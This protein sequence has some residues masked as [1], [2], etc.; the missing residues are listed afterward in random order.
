[1]ASSENLEYEAEIVWLDDPSKYDYV[2]AVPILT[3]SRD[4]PIRGIGDRIVGYAILR[5]DAPADYPRR[6]YR[7]VFHI[8]KGDRDDGKDRNKG[9]YAIGCPVE[10]VD[11]LTVA[12]GV[13]GEITER[14]WGGPLPK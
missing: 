13:K 14:A 5:P 4:K 8:M 6:W 1:V 9:P 7:R 3:G 11:P 12:P 10:S 2:R